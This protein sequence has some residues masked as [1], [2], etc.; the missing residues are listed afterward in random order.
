MRMA[1]IVLADFDRIIRDT[2]ADWLTASE[3]EALYDDMLRLL[4][5]ARW[6]VPA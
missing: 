3:Q 2:R 4:T 6:G 5:L 1:R